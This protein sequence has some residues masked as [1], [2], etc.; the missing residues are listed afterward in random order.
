MMLLDSKPSGVAYGLGVEMRLVVWCF[1]VGTSR[2]SL[3]APF[4]LQYGVVGDFGVVTSHR[5][6]PEVHGKW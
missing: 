2:L 3:T 1:E 4:Q 5:S 6:T